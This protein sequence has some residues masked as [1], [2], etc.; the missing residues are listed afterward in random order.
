MDFLG[1]IVSEGG[2]SLSE[3]DTK[4]V[5]DW[6]IPKS[7]REVEQFLGLANYHRNFIKNFARI[8]VCLYR[9]TGKNPFIWDEDQQ[10]AFEDLKAALT[11]APV[12]GLP[13]NSDPFIS[14]NDASNYAIGGELLQ[15][16]EEEERVIAYGSYA[17]AREQINYCTTRKELLAVVRFT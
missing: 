17:L 7:T 2:I 6:P 10:N 3:T 13:N 11:S 14:D 4:A 8:A 12:L 1:Q 9:V 16:Q 5:L 15:V